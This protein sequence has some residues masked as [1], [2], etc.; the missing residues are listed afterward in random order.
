MRNT[1]HYFDSEKMTHGD[2]NI[3]D[4]IYDKKCSIENL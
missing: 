4:I 2:N 1:L 3:Y